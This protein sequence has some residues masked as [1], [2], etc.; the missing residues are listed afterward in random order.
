MRPKDLIDADNAA[1]SS[2]IEDF[3]N[4]ENDYANPDELPEDNRQPNAKA[5]SINNQIPN[6][7]ATVS[8][9]NINNVSPTNNIIDGKDYVAK[10]SS[11]V[12]TSYNG[13]GKGSSGLG[14]EINKTCASHNMPYGTKIYIPELKNKLNTDGIL[15]VTDVGGPYYDFDICTNQSMKKCNM[16]VYILEW[17][18]G[19][20]APSYYKSIDQQID[21]G[22]WD[23][24]K[25]AWNIYKAMN[26]KLINF[27][28]YNQED[29]NIKNHPNYNDK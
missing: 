28:K 29:T 23:R 14:L 7:T 18:T 11:A 13:S 27:T 20:I 9:T 2:N 22:Q 1:S 12:C 17:G 5:R 6:Y 19:R 16:D 4:K 3:D 15:T 26:G 8:Y 21:L 25:A 24:Y 10:I